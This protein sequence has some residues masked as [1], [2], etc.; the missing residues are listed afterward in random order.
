VIFRAESIGERPRA[1]A[2]EV[3]SWEAAV[4]EIFHCKNPLGLPLPAVLFRAL[5]RPLPFLDGGKGSRLLSHGE[6]PFLF[7]R[8]FPFPLLNPRASGKD[9]ESADEGMPAAA[10][11]GE[12]GKR[13]MLFR[14]ISPRESLSSAMS[15]R[16]ELLRGSRLRQQLRRWLPFESTLSNDRKGL[17][18]A[19]PEGALHVAEGE[20]DFEI[21]GAAVV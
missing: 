20:L 13:E 18:R 1:G 7:L 2:T 3:E 16:D 15:G 6:R 9:R 10:E 21:G 5:F 17:R 12:R 8:A 14:R 19:G 11:G 4:S